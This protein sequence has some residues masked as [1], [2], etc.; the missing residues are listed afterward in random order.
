MEN[1]SSPPE[2]KNGSPPP[3]NNQSRLAT[4]PFSENKSRLRSGVTTLN[5]MYSFGHLKKYS[6]EE[7]AW[8]AWARR[9]EGDRGRAGVGGHVSGSSSPPRM[10]PGFLP[11]GG[12][13]FWNVLRSSPS[14]NTRTS[15]LP[16]LRAVHCKTLSARDRHSHQ[17]PCSLKP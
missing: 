13:R 14:N 8:I 15:R 3:P 2:E 6:K 9:K 7:S 5:T 1:S 11:L 10:L 12:R 4:C 16:P 17:R